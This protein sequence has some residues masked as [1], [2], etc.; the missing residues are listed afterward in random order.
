M[1]LG[2]REEAN[3]KNRGPGFD[4]QKRNMNGELGPMLRF[5]KIFSPKISAKK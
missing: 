2:E 5:L 4:P 1:W 3:E